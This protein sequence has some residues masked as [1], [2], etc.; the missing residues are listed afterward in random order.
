MTKSA[1]II[2]AS[3]TVGAKT[4]FKLIREKR[5][6]KKLYKKLARK[7]ARR[8]GKNCYREMDRFKNVDRRDVV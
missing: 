8:A 6:N 4:A 2:L 1:N 5:K 3:T 7:R